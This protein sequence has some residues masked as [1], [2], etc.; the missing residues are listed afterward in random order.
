MSTDESDLSRLEQRLG[1]W[2]PS[3]GG[4]DRDRLLYE[5]G[6]AESAVRDRRLVKVT[7]AVSIA[8]ALAAFGLGTAWRIEHDRNGRLTAE[9]ALARLEA[10]PALAAPY[11]P[12][13]PASISSE[14]PDP[15]S[16]LALSRR[17]ASGRIDFDRPDRPATSS[18]DKPSHPKPDSL[19]V[20]DRDRLLDL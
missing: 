8:T 16:Y 6:R 5:A 7:M 12:T 14:P 3:L 10:N 19:R 20:G 2:T 9:L 4:L 18:G 17:I 11:R 1:D 15:F 13:L